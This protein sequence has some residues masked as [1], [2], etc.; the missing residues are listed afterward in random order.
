MGNAITFSLPYPPSANRIWR[1]FR[2]RMVR[3]GE[4]V[5]WL[6]ACRM[7]IP[8]EAIGRVRGRHSLDIAVDRPDRRA[9]DLDNLCKP[10]LDA[11]KDDKFVKGVIRDDSDT[12]SI[13]IRW[14]DDAPVKEPRVTVCVFPE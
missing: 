13:T 3:S 1:K 14:R 2:G 6:Q 11:I 5:E 8:A 10:T 7:A 12:Q 4:Y 9:R